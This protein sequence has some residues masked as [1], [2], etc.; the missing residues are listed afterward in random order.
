MTMKTTVTNIIEAAEVLAGKTGYE[1]VEYKGEEFR[2]TSA[3]SSE[4]SDNGDITV[5]AAKEYIQDYLERLG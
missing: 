3:C 5:S 1:A 2:R 4:F